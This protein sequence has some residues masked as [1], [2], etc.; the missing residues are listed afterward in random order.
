[1]RNRKETKRIIKTSNVP[2]IQEKYVWLL[3]NLTNVESE[4]DL[5]RQFLVPFFNNKIPIV[6]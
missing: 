5:M 1:M 2:H 4:P 6:P 3:A